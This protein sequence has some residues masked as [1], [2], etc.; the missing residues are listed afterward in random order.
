MLI[1]SSPNEKIFVERRT[2][3]I[4]GQLKNTN[5]IE[6]TQ[7]Y[8]TQKGKWKCVSINLHKDLVNDLVN[9]LKSIS[10]EK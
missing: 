7:H 6:L 2:L 3:I 1:W 10:E 5:F 9:G 8:R 4:D